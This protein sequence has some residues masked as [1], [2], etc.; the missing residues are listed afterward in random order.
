MGEHYYTTNPEA[1]H[2]FQEIETELRGRKYL[3]MTDSGVFSKNR[4]DRGSE[5]MIEAMEIKPGDKI[6]D[7]G[8]GYGPIGIVASDLTGNEGRVVMAD[9]NQRAVDLVKENFKRNIVTNATVIQSDAYTNIAD[10]DFDVILTNPP[11]RAGKKV[12]YPMVEAAHAHLKT[13]G[14]L[15]TVC[16]TRQGAKSLA[17]KMEEV[18]G[19]VEEVEKGSGY[20]VYRA[21]RR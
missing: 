16:M 11:F 21:M 2:E 12:V 13:G 9:I 15:Y 7:M 1:R 4:I 20:R 19:E 8:C 6:L 5:L 14:V 3:F 18:F 10:R 17:K